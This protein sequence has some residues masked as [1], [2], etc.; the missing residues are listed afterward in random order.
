MPLSN[1][2]PLDM[3]E[4]FVT[5]PLLEMQAC[6]FSLYCAGSLVHMGHFMFV[7]GFFAPKTDTLH[8][9]TTVLHFTLELFHDHIHLLRLVKAFVHY[10]WN[11]S[12]PQLCIHCEQG[13]QR[14]PM[15]PDASYWS[16]RKSLMWTLWNFTLWG[17]KAIACVRLLY[18]FWRRHIN[19]KR[20]PPHVPILCCEAGIWHLGLVPSRGNKMASVD[21]RRKSGID[22]PPT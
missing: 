13:P 21:W 22:H 10:L 16:L 8:S 1:S 14:P 18:F 12:S 20:L 15:D 2:G 11:D 9:S 19:M 3:K 5:R 4:S 17:I 7:W 6:L